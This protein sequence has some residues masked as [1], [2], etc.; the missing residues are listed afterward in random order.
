MLL[1]QTPATVNDL[2]F[3]VPLF[4]SFGIPGTILLILAYTC[5][6]LV[7]W[8]TPH[9]ENLVAAWIKRQQIM[10]ECQVKLANSTIEIQQKN[11]TVLEASYP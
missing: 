11:T 8:G 3:L 10:E 6:K 7:M 9:V 1:A 4:Q 2:N 5:K